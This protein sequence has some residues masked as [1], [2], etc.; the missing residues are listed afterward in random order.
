MSYT[1]L[2]YR[3]DLQQDVVN[4]QWYKFSCFLLLFDFQV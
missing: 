1:Q 2:P 4:L 3:V